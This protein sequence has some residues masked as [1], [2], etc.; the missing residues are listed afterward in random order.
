[1]LELVLV[2]AFGDCFLN[3]L[4][5]MATDYKRYKDFLSDDIA[6]TVFVSEIDFVE[7]F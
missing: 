2:A 3:I 5:A 1:M 4:R 6:V 7:S